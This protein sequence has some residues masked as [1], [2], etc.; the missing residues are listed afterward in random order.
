MEAASTTEEH[1][2][3]VTASTPVSGATA[4]TIKEKRA[5]LRVIEGMNEREACRTQGV[6]R[7]TLNDWRKSAES[8]FGYTGCEKTLACTPGRRE[9]I[10]VGIELITFMKDTRRDSE[11]LTAKTV[12]SFVHDEYREWLEGYVEGKKDAVTAYE[13]LLRLLRCFAYRR[14]SC[15]ELP[16]ASR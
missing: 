12:A 7:W 1:P 2:D 6:P 13:S 15:S 3:E 9:V 5:V 4:A 14:G 11:V 16:V 8:I 10:P